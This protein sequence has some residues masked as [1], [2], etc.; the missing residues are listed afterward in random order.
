MARAPWMIF[1]LVVACLIS[2]INFWVSNKEYI[3]AQQDLDS[4]AMKYKGKDIQDS[5]EDVVR[6]LKIRYGFHILEASPTDFF[7]MNAGGWM[8]QVC[9][10]HVSLTEY[11]LIFSTVMET[12][13]HSGRY[14]L[15]ISDFV[16]N[17]WME[18]WKEKTFEAKNFTAGTTVYHPWL[19]SAGVRFG[20]NSWFLEYGRGFVPSSIFFASADV[21]F[22]THDFVAWW[23]MICSFGRGFAREGFIAVEEFLNQYRDYY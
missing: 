14:W 1:L 19:T 5:F 9:A 21:L 7:L 22:S 12:Q 2:L 18:Q 16:I 11:V 10:L 4:I 23:E 17:G 13:G 15:N 6:D 3:F 8:G 20:A